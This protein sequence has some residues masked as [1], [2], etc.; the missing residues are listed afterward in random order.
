MPLLAKTLQSR[1]QDLITATADI[2]LSFAAASD[3]IPHA[4]KLQLFTLLATS[5]GPSESLH[6]II[7]TVADRVHQSRDINRFAPI[8]L[9][10]FTVV[11]A[12]EVRL[13]LLLE[14]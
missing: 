4:R 11:E 14:S 1:D 5:L 3:H 2:L 10:Q 6:A 9:Q 7:A 8:L 13:S 12:L